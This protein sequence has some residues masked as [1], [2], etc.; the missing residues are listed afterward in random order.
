[1]NDCFARRDREQLWEIAESLVE[2]TAAYAESERNVLLN[3]AAGLTRLEAESAY[4]LSLFRH[5]R[6]TSDEI[7]QLKSRWLQKSGM[8]RLHKGQQG[9]ELLGGLENL[10]QFC[11]HSLRGSSTSK[12]RPRGVML[13]GVPGTGKSAFAKASGKGDG[14]ARAGA[15]RGAVDDGVVMATYIHQLLQ[16]RKIRSVED[17]RSTVYE[18]GLKRIRPCMMTTVTTL[19]ALIPVLIATGR[20]ADV[21]RAMAIPVFG[22]MLAEPFTSFIVPTLYSAYLELK[23]RF[24]F[25]DP[26]WEGT[27]EMP[28]APNEERLNAA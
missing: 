18:A 1:M 27:E 10:K 6:V 5:G 15:G 4:S 19:A 9:Y 26:L 25:S 12:A 2:D 17:I 20:G 13:L 7:W 14:S 22:G 11:L 16:K 23:M 8:L 3:S 21:A 28:S 24:G